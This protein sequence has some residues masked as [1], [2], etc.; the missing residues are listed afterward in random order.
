MLFHAAAEKQIGFV[1]GPVSGGEQ[2]ALKR[3][4]H[5]YVVEREH[6]FNRIE[7]V[8]SHYARSVRRPGSRRF[9]P[10]TKMVNQIAIAGLLQGLAEAIA[11]AEHAG[12]PTGEVIDVISK[13]CLILANGK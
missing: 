1:D 10:K 7:P 6:D 5:H 13:G 9:W 12:L 8:I 2:G 3:S 11:F 4:A